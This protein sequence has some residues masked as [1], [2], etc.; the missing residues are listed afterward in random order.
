MRISKIKFRIVVISKQ[1]NIGIEPRN[2]TQGLN[3]ICTFYF[4][5]KKLED[6]W[7]NKY[8]E[9]KTFF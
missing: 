8:H 2:D 4:L 7:S 6:I 5:K 3:Y 1:E 9:K